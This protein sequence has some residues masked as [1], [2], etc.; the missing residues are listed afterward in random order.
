[1]L[2]NVS[3]YPKEYVKK[4]IRQPQESNLPQQPLLRITTFLVI[5]L[6]RW[7]VNRVIIEKVQHTCTYI[8]YKALTITQLL[9]EVSVLDDN[10]TR[11]IPYHLT[12]FARLNSNYKLILEF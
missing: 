7:V 9:H 2:M 1:M 10:V 5:Q 3:R 11:F 6:I 8:L 12:I 4:F